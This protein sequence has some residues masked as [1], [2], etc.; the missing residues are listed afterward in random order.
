VLDSQRNVT[1]NQCRQLLP[2]ERYFRID[3][4][5]DGVPELDQVSESLRSRFRD[6]AEGDAARAFGS[7]IVKSILK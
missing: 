5:I 7:A 3:R 4:Q 6:Y 2:R 1:L